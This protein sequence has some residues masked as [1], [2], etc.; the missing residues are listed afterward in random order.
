M[1]F[2]IFILFVIIFISLFVIIII[3]ILFVIYSKHYLIIKRHTPHCYVIIRRNACK[4][5][6]TF[7][8]LQILSMSCHSMTDVLMCLV[9][10]GGVGG[11]GRCCRCWEVLRGVGRC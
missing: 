7:F 9:G 1:Y 11:V 5:A 3:I 6:H 4:Q 8:P 2:F 10:V